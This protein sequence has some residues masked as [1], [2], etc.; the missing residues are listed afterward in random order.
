MRFVKPLVYTLFSVTLFFLTPAKAQVSF[1]IVPLDLKNPIHQHLLN[2][3][4]VSVAIDTENAQANEWVG[5]HLR[6]IFKPKGQEK[7]A[8]S[9]S[10]IEMY[11]HSG[12]LPVDSLS[13]A[14]EDEIYPKLNSQNSSKKEVWKLQRN[15]LD[16]IVESMNGYATARFPVF[17]DTSDPSSSRW[18]AKNMKNL[19]TNRFGIKFLGGG[20]YI[21]VEG[22]LEREAILAFRSGEI[23]LPTLHAELFETQIP[24]RLRGQIKPFGL[25]C[26][27][28]FR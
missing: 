2:Y 23:D 25:S 16:Q 4:L 3:H 24:S 8:I 5:R 18:L 7:Y 1:G 27:G 11:I 6:A 13:L 26:R 9:I 19:E 10:G 21:K 15:D 20:R 12:E 17:I 28:M 14:V 22:Y